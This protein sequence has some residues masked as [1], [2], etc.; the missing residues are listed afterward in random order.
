[1]TV[2][3]ISNFFLIFFFGNGVDVHLE[4]AQQ[5]IFSLFLCQREFSGD[6]WSSADFCSDVYIPHGNAKA[7]TTGLWLKGIEVFN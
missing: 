5:K 3:L 2:C 4:I 7:V 6:F 1:M